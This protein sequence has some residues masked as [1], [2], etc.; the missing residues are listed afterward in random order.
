MQTGST[1]LAGFVFASSTDQIKL[2]ARSLN[3]PESL[4]H[5]DPDVDAAER[6]RR[7]GRRGGGE[8]ETEPTCQ[9]D[10]VAAVLGVGGARRR[11]LAEEGVDAL[12]VAPQGGER[13]R[14]PPRLV[15]L[16][17]LPLP[18]QQHL[19]GLR[20]AVV[21]LQRRRFRVRACCHDNRS[22]QPSMGDTFIDLF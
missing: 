21:R 6:G 8:V 2:D 17:H 20:V 5:L 15:P 14:G 22:L 13:Q 19:Q 9:V 4:T 18:L 10:R 7:R 1:C 11:P 12:G 16:V 3:G